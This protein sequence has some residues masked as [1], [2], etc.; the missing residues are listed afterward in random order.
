[1]DVRVVDRLDEPEAPRRGRDAVDHDVGLRRHDLVAQRAVD[2]E[3][4][5]QRSAQVRE[6]IERRRA[7]GRDSETRDELR[8]RAARRGLEMA[9]RAARVVEA[10]A[11]PGGRRQWLLE[12]DLAEVE[13]ILLRRAQAGQGSAY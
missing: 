7:R 8:A 3:R 13:A 2:R 9:V 5:E 10:R 6:R 12:D 1:E 4:L 11:E